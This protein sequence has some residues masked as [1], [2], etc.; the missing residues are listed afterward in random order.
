M[1]VVVLAR[2]AGSGLRPGRDAAGTA[3]PVHARG[4]HDQDNRIAAAV[5]AALVII[6]TPAVHGSPLTTFQ[7]ILGR[8]VPIGLAVAAG[9]YIRARADYVTGLQDRAERLE[10][11]QKLLASQAVADERVRIAREL[12]DVVAHNVS[13]MVVQAQALAATGADDE[14]KRRSGGWR[15]SGARHSRRCNGCSACCGLRTGWPTSAN[16]SRECATSRR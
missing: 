16:L 2:G 12:H 1:L 6:G 10:R 9:L 5:V 3:G 14:Q 13:L 7:P 4:V 8:L 11:E 15:A